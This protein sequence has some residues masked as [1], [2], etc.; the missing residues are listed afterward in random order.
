MPVEEIEPRQTRYG[1]VADGDGWFV[2]NATAS[3]WNDTGPFG[4]Y[5]NFEGKRRFKQLGLNLNVL[6]PGQ[7]LGY[8][9]RERAQEDFLVLSGECLLLVEGQERRLRAWDFVHCPPETAHMIVGAGDGPALVLAVG[10][11]GRGRSGIVYPV[12][13]LALEHGVGVRT[14]TTK[15]QEAYRGLPR[16]TRVAYRPG[17]LPE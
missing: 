1:L 13:R 5:C 16:R 15:P 4:F 7:S 2:L 12:D 11:R 9:H 17:W 6:E 10:A 3:R 8:Y 14:E